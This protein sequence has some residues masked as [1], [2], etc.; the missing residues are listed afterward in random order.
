MLRALPELSV[1]PLGL[2]TE[3]GVLHYARGLGVSR[4]MI[5]KY[6][7]ELVLPDMSCPKMFKSFLRGVGCVVVSYCSGANVG[8]RA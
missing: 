5:R 1:F 2:L 8:F 6:V 4:L 3:T 7:Y